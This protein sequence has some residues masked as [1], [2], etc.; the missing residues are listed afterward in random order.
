MVTALKEIG[1]LHPLTQLQG[2]SP[3]KRFLPMRRSADHDKIQQMLDKLDASGRGL[4]VMWLSRRTPAL[5]VAGTIQALMIGTKE[6]ESNSRRSRFS[7]YGW[8]NQEQEDDSEFRI[9]GDVENNRLLMWASDAEY[10]E[11]NGLLEKLGVISSP[12][13]GNPSQVRVLDARSPEETA[14][15]LE[16]LQRAWG[17]KNR[18]HIQGRSPSLPKEAPSAKQKPVEPEDADKDEADADAATSRDKLTRHALPQRQ[19]RRFAMPG[20]VGQRPRLLFSRREG[21]QDPLASQ[22]ADDDTGRAEAEAPPIHGD[23]HSRRADPAQFGRC[24]RPR[25]DRGSDRGTRAADKE[26]RFFNSRTRGRVWS[27]ST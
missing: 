27:S 8:G 19:E 25:P 21:R 16:Q 20:D 1:N 2:D 11:V 6:K 7:F 12:E 14:R 10:E 15:L 4:N 13:A 26:F 5:Q 23:R 3:A 24:G 17:G 9:Q 18:L 22:P